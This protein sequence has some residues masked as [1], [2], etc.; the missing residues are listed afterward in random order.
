MENCKIG[1]TWWANFSVLVRVTLL[2]SWPIGLLASESN[3]L[4]IKDA[5]RIAISTHPDVRGAAAVESAGKQQILDERAD[6]FP[7]IDGK[8]ESGLEY[9]NNSTTRGRSSRP[10]SGGQPGVS[11]LH[12]LGELTATQKIFDGFDTISRV[13]AAENRTK[14]A[15]FSLIDTTEAIA[16]R[17]VEAYL[18]VNR[19]RESVRL[20]EENAGAHSEVVEDAKF[21]AEGGQGEGADVFQAQSREA[22]SKARLRGIRGQLRRA[23][24]D[25][26]EVIGSF[27]ETLDPAIPDLNEMSQSLDDALAL[28]IKNNP[29]LNSKRS[30]SFA[31]RDDIK[32]SK[33]SFW[34][35]LD[36]ELTSQR[37]QNTGG[38]RGPSL[39]HKGLFVLRYNFFSGGRDRA[40]Y[41]RSIKLAERASQDEASVQRLVE[42]QI[43]F[44]YANFQTAADRLPFLKARVLASVEVVDGY[45]SQFT[46]GRR[47]LLDVLDVKNELFQAKVELVNGFTE[48][49]R[50]QF[51]FHATLGQLLNLLGLSQADINY[52]NDA[53]NPGNSK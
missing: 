42:E 6:F 27:P 10:S 44:D 14:A 24:A 29:V 50:T 38:T 1:S 30:E 17:A 34:P 52:K 26:N 51:Q 41:H 40:R 28:A 8:G 48:L 16:L 11:T 32:A 39:S 7:T 13:R 31:A 5:V 35:T 22:L 53:N 15:R 47:T 18:E 49:K 36:L 19:L 3:A 45:E 21:S 43:R 2:V 9:V 25:F 33:S 4:T 23:E 37:Q 12:N 20:A 46:I